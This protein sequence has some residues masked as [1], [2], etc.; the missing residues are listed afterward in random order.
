MELSKSWFQL[1]EGDWACSL[2]VPQLWN[3]REYSQ[4]HI[5]NG[6]L[7]RNTDQNMS[8]VHGV[9]GGVMFGLDRLNVARTV[10]LSAAASRLGMSNTPMPVS[11][12]P[13]GRQALF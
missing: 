5:Q 6:A 3:E 11:Y 2:E 1:A 12:P 13:I 9:Y 10:P 4:V 7:V 8:R